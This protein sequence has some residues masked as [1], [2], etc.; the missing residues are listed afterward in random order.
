L[1]RLRGDFRR[2]QRLGKDD[3]L[4]VWHRTPRPDWLSRDQA[5]ALPEEITLREVRV[6]VNVPGF[7]TR[8]LIV[9]TTLLD[10][11]AYPATK[12][13]DLYRRRWQAE[14]NLRSLKTQMQM[15][16][17]RTMKPATVR[18]EFATYLLAYNCVRRLTLEA[19]QASGQE[20][21]QISFKGTLQSLLEFLARFHQIPS[22]SRWVEEL[23]A[24]IAQLHVGHRPNRIEPYAGQRRPKDY[25]P[26][27]EPRDIYKRRLRS[28][29]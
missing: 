15:E 25:P 8:S 16:Q 26:L 23:L 7:R 10:A 29:T 5:D 19:A 2:G 1:G 28:N 18:K 13:A 24:T 12:L 6:R 3:H 22:V 11:E 21:W 27:N 20:P 4:V 9:V 14:L 17:L